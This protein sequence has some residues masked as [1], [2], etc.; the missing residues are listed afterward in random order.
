M[1][2]GNAK[3]RKRRNEERNREKENAEDR[4]NETTRNDR[5]LGKLKKR[6]KGGRKRRDVREELEQ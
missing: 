2:K 3:Y 6:E 1:R 4:R 5:I